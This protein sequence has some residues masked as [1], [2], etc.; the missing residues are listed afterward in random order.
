MNTKKKV[1]VCDDE[2]H[3]L[4][5]VSYIVREEG[6]ELITAEDGEEGLRLART[7]SPD[8]VLLDVMMPKLQ[9]F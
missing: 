9:R 8:L 1:L 6:Y 2:L 4:E 7:E 3:I 5:L